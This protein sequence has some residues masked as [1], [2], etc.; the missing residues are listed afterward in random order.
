MQRIVE[1]SDLRGELRT[2]ISAGGDG[3]ATA[4]LNRIPSRVPLTIFPLGSEN[5]LAQEL[6]LPREPSGVL[7]MVQQMAT[8]QLDLFRANGSLFLLM[9]SVGFDAQVVRIVHESRR[10]HITRWA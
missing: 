9:A 4:I 3:T 2:V 5:L 1:G 10:S 7:P 6:K 8:R